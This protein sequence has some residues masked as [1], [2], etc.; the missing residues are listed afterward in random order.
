MIK[1]G[2]I[3]GRGDLPAGYDNLKLNRKIAETLYDPKVL[4]GLPVGVMSPKGIHPDLLAQMFIG[5][6]ASGSDLVAMLANIED[7]NEK[8]QRLVDEKMAEEFPDPT[9]DGTLSDKAIQALHNDASTERRLFEIDQMMKNKPAAVKGLVKKFHARRMT[10][11]QFKNRAELTLGNIAVRDIKPYIY[12]R[13]E[14]RHSKDAMDKFLKADF[15][16]NGDL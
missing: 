15:E 2:V 3:E 13:A 4:R 5:G 6:N 8:I 7:R 14:I 1:S 10:V 11:A 16:A 12:Q 9:I